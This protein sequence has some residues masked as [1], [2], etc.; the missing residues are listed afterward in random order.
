MAVASGSVATPERMNPVDAWFLYAEDDVN[1]MHIL[2]FI[3]LESRSLTREEYLLPFGLLG[4]YADLLGRT[5]K[6]PAAG[7]EGVRVL[8]DLRVPMPDGVELL[9]DLYTPAEAGP[10]PT[11]LVRTPYGRRGAYGLLYG[12]VYAQ[13]GLQVLVQ[14]VRGTFGSGGDYVPFDERAGRPRDARVDRGTALARRQ[15]RLDG[16]ELP[17]ARAVGRGRRRR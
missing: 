8:R 9:A 17:R 6:L 2:S 12:L 11:V 10:M 1:H 16:R 13:R 4:G 5:M 3:V 7:R 15:D 14:S